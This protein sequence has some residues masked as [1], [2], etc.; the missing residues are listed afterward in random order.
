M[1]LERSEKFNYEEQIK[2]VFNL[3]KIGTGTLFEGPIKL[4]RI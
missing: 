4:Q 1:M 3:K 2:L